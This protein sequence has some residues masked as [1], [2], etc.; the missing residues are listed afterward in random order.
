MTIEE[1]ALETARH[2]ST[3]VATE[4]LKW[5]S[6]YL[7]RL[8]TKYVSIVLAVENDSNDALRDVEN[9]CAFMLV[10]GCA[11]GWPELSR[12]A[13]VAR[14]ALLR[15]PSILDS[16]KELDAVMAICEELFVAWR[17]ML[18]PLDLAGDDACAG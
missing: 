6:G 18:P 1:P 17:T 15:R 9:A 13:G 5:R 4:S 2:R 16:H 10:T 12:V 7:E 11:A 8:W 14:H 3:A